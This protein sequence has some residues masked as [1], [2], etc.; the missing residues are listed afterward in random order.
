MWWL[1]RW[2]SEKQ[3]HSLSPWSEVTGSKL[4]S[5][6]FQTWF[7][8]KIA[9]Q[10]FN[11]ALT[12]SFSAMLIELLFVLQTLSGAERQSR[13]PVEGEYWANLRFTFNHW[14]V[15]ILESLFRFRILHIFSFLPLKLPDNFEVMFDEAAGELIVGGIYLRL[16]IQQ[17]A[18]VRRLNH[19]RFVDMKVI[20]W[21]NY[22]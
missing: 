13:H 12:Y 21:A 2:H 22:F 1:L 10:G 9:W 3:T 6:T 11:S 14:Y 5:P 17:P 4:R 8:E 16:F 18:W 19:V 20:F 7:G 15:E